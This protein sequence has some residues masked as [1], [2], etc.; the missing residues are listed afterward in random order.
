MFSPLFQISPEGVVI[1]D[2][3]VFRFA[4]DQ[5]IPVIMLTSGETL[6]PNFCSLFPQLHYGTDCTPVKITIHATSSQGDT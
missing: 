5:N 2:E 1:R 4:R 6:L 3:K